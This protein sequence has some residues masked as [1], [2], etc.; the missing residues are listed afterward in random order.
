[1]PLVLDVT[2]RSGSREIELDQDSFW[3]GSER[4][5]CAVELDLP[6][7]VG[8]L[9]EVARDE[10]GRVRVRAEPGLP[11]PVRCATGSIGSRFEN[12]LDGDVLN[13]GPALVKLRYRAE[14][15]GDN[16]RELDPAAL[17][18]APGSPVGA[19]YQTFTEMADHLEGLRSQEQLLP[20]AMTAILRATGADR[21]AILLDDDDDG[22]AFYMSRPKD[23]RAFRISRSLVDQVRA[24][25]RVV[26]VPVAASDPVAR[27]FHSVRSE[28]ISSAVAL[29]IQALGKMLGV[30]YADCTREGAVLSAEDLQ[31]MVFCSRMLATS[32]GNRVLVR[33]LLDRDRDS[34]RAAHWALET[35]SKACAELVQRVELYAPADYTVLLRGETGTGKEVLARALHDLSRRRLGPFVPVNC[36]AIPEQLMESMLFG[37]EKGAFTGALQARRG[38]F[39]E[40]HGG[41]ILLDE[42]GDMA[43]E[44]QAKILR[45]LQDRVVTPIGG[46]RQVR[47]DVRILAATHQDLERMVR[48]GRFR[49]DLYYRLRELEIVLPP[50]RERREDIPML[51]A[52]FL[53]LAAEELGHEEVPT[54][55][56]EAMAKL[57]AAPWRGN[58]RELQHVV[59]GAALRAGGGP[60][61]P[62]HLEL[63][64][65]SPLAAPAVVTEPEPEP[66]EAQASTWKER[67]EAQEKEAL[68]RTLAEASGNLTRAAELFGVPRT[69]YREK[70]VRHGLLAP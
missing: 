67:L 28:G 8:R 43:L 57:Q 68:Q 13:L 16:V 9:L 62:A 53:A 42:I 5:G 14:A 55:S 23:Q 2:D 11:F 26:H 10:R 21:V 63:D 3:I 7:V 18:P 35:R 39:E 47:V 41:T 56:T 46:R 25:G 17:T 27:T 1:M 66:D 37:H 69:T 36:A 38:H 40:A 33:S 30:V 70:L 6:G 58:I 44:L 50:L 4:S 48:E 29:P 60:I 32:L 24:A 52:R 65:P 49:E 12:V 19:W 59:K 15:S 20:A 31:R 51:V 64:R 34:S 54:I 61:L 45:L 22:Q